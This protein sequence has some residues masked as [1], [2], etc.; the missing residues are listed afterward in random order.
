MF[1]IGISKLSIRS[2][3]KSI[4]GFGGYIAISGYRSLW[5]IFRK[6]VFELAIVENP[7]FAVGKKCI[8]STK[9]CG[10]FLLPSATRVRKIEAQ[11]EGYRAIILL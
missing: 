11:Y 10:G 2:R 9:T 4:S 1:V 6:T 8:C 7:R 3:D 5:K